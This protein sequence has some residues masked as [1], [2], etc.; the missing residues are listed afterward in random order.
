MTTQAKKTISELSQGDL[1]QKVGEICTAV[2][3][4]ASSKEL[5]E[6]SLVKTMD[7]FHANRGSI[8]LM[9]ESG[10][11]LVLKIA[12]GMEINEQEMLV[13]R[14]GEGIV[15]KVAQIKEPLI[16]ED[17]ASDGRFLGFKSQGSYRTPSFICAP[18]LI[19][20]KLI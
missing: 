16:V 8:F 13:K 9:N 19:K 7:L 15:G 20:D 17:I 10:T 4:V 14:L 12:Q 11:E 3:V 1:F 18:L 6:I 2:T 5:L